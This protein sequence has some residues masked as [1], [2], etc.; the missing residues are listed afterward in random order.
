VP[1]GLCAW[2]AGQ[3]QRRGD[4]RQVRTDRG[5]AGEQAATG[6]AR[7]PAERIGERRRESDSLLQVQRA[8]RL[9]KIILRGSLGT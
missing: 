1:G 3:G 9:M 6:A 8:R 4:A 7:R 2:P 5:A